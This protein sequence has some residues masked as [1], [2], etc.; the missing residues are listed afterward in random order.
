MKR[1]IFLFSCLLVSTILF[2]F[3]IEKVNEFAF[4][5]FFH[6][7]MNNH[8]IRNDSLFICNRR[9]FQIYDLS[10]GYFN[11]ITDYSLK[12]IISSM[13][14]CDNRVFLVSASFYRITCLSIDDPT[15]PEVLTEFSWPYAYLSFIAGEY[16]Y[17]H[18]AVNG[19]L[20][21]HVIDIHSFEEVAFYPVP[22]NYNPLRKVNETMALLDL[23]NE[24]WL[25]DLSDPSMI[26]AMGH[27]DLD[28]RYASN[29]FGTINDT[30]LVASSMGPIGSS[31]FYSIADPWNWTLLSEIQPGTSQYDYEGGIYYSWR[32]QKS[33]CYDIT[34]ITQPVVLDSF[35]IVF[36]CFQGSAL[37]DD[38][39]VLVDYGTMYL[40]DVS[41]HTYNLLDTKHSYGCIRH[42]EIFNETILATPC[43]NYGFTL[44]DVSDVLNVTKLNSYC[45]NEISYYHNPAADNIF[46]YMGFNIQDE[47]VNHRI[48]EIEPDGSAVQLHSFQSPNLEEFFG[49]L[50]YDGSDYYYAVFDEVLYQYHL[51]QQNELEIVA[52]MPLPGVVA[53]SFIFV[54]SA[55][56]VLTE[57]MMYVVDTQNMEIVH[58]NQL[59]YTPI[60]ITY[61]FYDN[62]LIY[63]PGSWCYTSIYDIS[64]PTDPTLFSFIDKVGALAVDAENDLLFIGDKNAS[65]FDLTT[66]D[67]GVLNE[68]ATFQNWTKGK[69]VIPL[70][71][72]GHNYFLYVEETSVAVYEYTTGDFSPQIPEVPS[73]TLSN[74]PNPFNPT[75]TISFSLGNEVIENVAIEIYNAKGQKVKQLQMT[76]DELRAGSVQWDGTDSA[77][78]PVTSGVYL[79]QLKADG[80]ALAQK[81]CLLLK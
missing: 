15:Q 59:A 67:T 81:K 8:V 79:Y 63:S 74:F 64:N 40:F 23:E 39:F 26:Q 42:G 10:Q 73:I 45:E 19:D 22:Y 75:T 12:G 52:S 2:S 76:N 5:E 78:Q 37:E 60:T 58:Q 33:R 21:L 70:K 13:T 48:F 66:I 46:C 6:A 27:A 18:E 49:I 4:S 50:T 17:S 80:K 57:Y 3:E 11:L 68:I 65:V 72:N 77:N 41:Q 31:Q 53:A 14:L 71:Q 7:G 29:E 62:Y 9:S 61:D 34:D 69:E 44:W 1:W 56:Y 36:D 38:T 28:F 54:D 30:I 35:S 16:L 20:Y 25:Y 43:T 32:R 24:T 51:N 55:V 47:S